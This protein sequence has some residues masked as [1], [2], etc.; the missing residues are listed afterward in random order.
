MAGPE[1]LLV[2]CTDTFYTEKPEL[3]YHLL[4]GTAIIYIVPWKDGNPQR[5]VALC[6]ANPGQVIPVF[7][8]ADAISHTD[9]RFAI[10]PQDE[11]IELEVI[12]RPATKLLQKRFLE[13]AKIDTYQVEGFEDSLIE[14]YLKESLKN[15]IFVARNSEEGKKVREAQ[16]HS[17]F[18][19]FAGN[20]SAVGYDSGAFIKAVAYALKSLNV[21]LADADKIKVKP[22]VTL[23]DLKLTASFDYRDVVLDGDWYN[24]DC[25]VILGNI[26]GRSIACVPG[27]GG[28]Y[29]IYYGDDG[30]KEK[31]TKDIAASVDPQAKVLER[32]LP[33]GK[34]TIK[35]AIQH[36]LGGIRKKD[37]AVVIVLEV[38][39]TLIG[40]LMPKLNQKIYD[41]YIPMGN[42]NVL[43]E[44]CLFIGTFMIGNIFFSLVESLFTFIVQTRAGYDL[45]NAAY[46]R[47]FRMPQSFFRKY[48]SAD[49]AGRLM[50]IGS[51]VNSLAGKVLSTGLS[52]IISFLYIF[53]MIK[54]AKKLTFVSL[55][56]VVA[57]SLAAMVF[58]LIAVKKT[59]IIEEKEA[60]ASSKLFQFICGIDKIRM[61]GVEDR[62]LAEYMTPYITARQEDVK[63]GRLDTISG[64][65]LGAGNTIFS[66]VLYYMIVKKDLQLSMGNFIAFNTAF[67]TVS[68]ALMSLLGLWLEYIQNKPV[69]ERM[70]P[71]IIE[72]NEAVDQKDEIVDLKGAVSL[73]HVTF[74]YDQNGK[75][76]LNDLSFAINPGEYVGIVGP[77]GCGK[78]TVLKMLLGF[79][80][81]Q[82]GTVMYDGKDIDSINLNSLR[83]HLGTVLQNGQL[84]SGSIF[85]NIS[86]S[87]PNPTMDDVNKVIEMV[88]LK[89]D[90]DMMP[91][92][93]HT[94]VSEDG[95][96]ISGGQKQRILIA[97]A[98]FN[99][100]AVLLFDEATS[101]LDNVTQAKVA[102]SLDGMKITRV[103]IAHR[104]STIRN[105][106]RILVINKGELIEEGN[107]DQLMAKKGMF[108]Q[109][110]NRQLAEGEDA[111]DNTQD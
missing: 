63:K 110:A 34:L 2:S 25:G 73:N 11:E 7:N 76:V 107:Y 5:R 17:M 13:S 111:D 61:T 82:S 94:V 49:L 60:K 78:S 66:M 23:D 52:S 50:S 24:N 33:D 67:G 71:V 44:M 19:F 90:V 47:I 105:C 53:E 38:I 43:V 80:K 55:L 36:I 93:V 74:S 75:N 109:M 68:G 88:G 32:V 54:Y 96:T 30:H 91:M 57:Y 1:K 79:E 56:M 26:N 41:E 48:D 18:N 69:I 16:L 21:N 104:L 100:P 98:I 6:E 64:I 40:I 103:V 95:G 15:R 8:C 72:E 77:S 46:R 106:D 70:A 4:K 37:I 31:L 9:W 85:E 97:R 39:C 92:G 14:V 59:T 45:Q 3:T 99:K 20:D 87:T 101:A 86:I 65:L 28:K 81:P 10:V 22:N 62:A 42:L 102:E 51:I 108:W 12:P 29:T 89:D 58:S 83:R 35:K 27:V 84:I